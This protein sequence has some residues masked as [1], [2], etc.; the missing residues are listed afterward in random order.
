MARARSPP[1]CAES[2]SGPTSRRWPETTPSA[3]VTLL[4]RDAAYRAL[5]KASRAGL[6]ARFAGWLE[7][8]DEDGSFADIV[9]YHLEQ[10]H[11]YAAETGGPDAGELGSRAGRKLAQTARRALARGDVP[12]G[13]NLLER[14]VAGVPAG[15]PQRVELEVELGHALTVGGE[16][17][18]AE[19]VLG[20]A[21]AE[22][23]GNERLELAAEIALAGVGSWKDG[24]PGAD[25][26]AAIERA[27]PIFERLDDQLGL[28]RAY[29]WLADV[30]NNEGALLARIECLERALEHAR[31]AGA[32]AEEQ[33]I[34]TYLG[35]PIANGP[36]PVPAGIRRIN[37]NLDQP[38][39]GAAA[40][41]TLLASLAELVAMQGRFDEALAL[42][43]RAVAIGEEFGLTFQLARIRDHTMSRPS[44]A[45]CPGGGGARGSAGRRTHTRRWARPPGDRPM[46][47][48]WRWCSM[49]RADTT[50]LG[51]TPNSVNGFP[52][53]MMWSPWRTGARCRPDSAPGAASP[54]P[55]AGWRARQWR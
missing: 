1:S 45:R 14:A 55:R 16:F 52:R 32:P 6:H 39:I 40:E 20:R 17:A 5:P 12:A 36:I 34:L 35:A 30:R 49:T 18:R 23:A 26:E 31:R 43:D 25:V 10:A 11:K 28:A 3:S 48:Y 4:I 22:A 42:V 47:S 21:R 44:A 41:M 7:S 15:D 51:S 38:G 8:R 33:A 9:A 54:M 24:T 19:E 37:A 46:P 2:S 50:K 27:L 29:D 53:R 13:A